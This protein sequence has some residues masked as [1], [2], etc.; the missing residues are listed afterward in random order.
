VSIPSLADIYDQYVT[1]E[2]DKCP[3]LVESR[4]SIVFGEGHPDPDIVFV[5][6]G[7]GYW[8]D[9]LA[10]PFVGQAGV[11]LDS[12]LAYFGRRSNSDLWRLGESVA[13]GKNLSDQESDLVREELI[14]TEKVHYLNAVLCR[15]P[16]NVE[17]SKKEV[18][19]CRER[20]HQTIYR[21][22]PLLIVAT[23]KVAAKA[24]LGKVLNV[25]DCRGQVYDL[26]IPGVTG[27]IRYPMLLTFH[28]SYVNRVG[29]FLSKTGPGVQFAEDCEHLLALV[30]QTRHLT[31]G[32]PVPERR[33]W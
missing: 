9:E 32:T 11:L 30:D 13:K 4:T 22:D 16:E 3:R 23:G 1:Q 10:R 33:K 25:Q 24:L 18:D 28:P 2:C 14:E 27:G 5:G 6:T 12:F 31:C 20:L 8:E 26:E 21:L 15:P 7:P 17:P 29:D 19:A